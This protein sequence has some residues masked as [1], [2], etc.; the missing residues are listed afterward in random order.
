MNRDADN[1]VDSLR[2][3]AVPIGSLSPDPRNTRKHDER[4]LSVIKSSLQRFGQRLPLVVQKQG[5][6]VRAGNGRLE[7]MR[8]LGWSEVAAV[9]V[10]EDDVEATAF[11]IADN[12]SAELAEWD[13]EELGAAL[14]MLA[15]IG[16]DMDLESFG[17]DDSEIDELSRELHGETEEIIPVPTDETEPDFVV[18]LEP[19]THTGDV[20]SLGQHKLYCGDCIEVMKTIPDNSVDAIVTDPPYGIGFLSSE[21][22]CEVPGNDFAEQAFRVLKPGGYIV[23]FAATRTI[24][25][26]TTALEDAKF[27]IRDQIAWA[28]WQ[29][30]PK[31]LNVSVAIDE[32]FD[33]KR[34]VVGTTGR[35]VGKQ[36]KRRTQG[37]NGSKAFREN[38]NNPGNLLTEPSTSE[39]KYWDGYHTA[40]KPAYEP[41]VLARKPLDGTVV[42]NILRWGT[43]A[44]NV[45]KCRYARGDAAWPGPQEEWDVANPSGEHLHFSTG[46][47]VSGA[48]RG[49][50][51]ST[52]HELG[53]FPANI[54][55]CKKPS[56]SE[57][58]AGCGEL[59]SVTGAESV[60]RK[61]NTAGVNNP[62]AGAGRTAS[63]VHNHHP[64]V[65]PL[66]LMEWL[67]RMVMPPSNGVV[68]EP[69]CGSGTTLA[70]VERTGNGHKCIAIEL[71]PKYCDIIKARWE[72]HRNR[73]C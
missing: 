71:E 48:G 10:D 68:L 63:T 39:A 59:S 38:K 14:D 7:A 36:G 72:H 67:V 35:N 58:E 1:I 33:A 25:R 13:M 20:V 55:Y 18:P 23:A 52:M 60:K 56:R 9:I 12:R 29:G 26:L 50:S 53:R 27:E 57:R 46:R 16:Q 15:D 3:L 5:M 49:D 41:A 32:H 70:A 40:L 65:K 34:K 44:L 30:F 51:R 69:F 54:Y 66:R 24:H 4:N 22:D 2:H 42:K 64:T 17:W 73:G 43:G 37:L 19:N 28:Q 45:D 61:A 8:A 62:R 11:S 6:V 47:G 31:A 21:W